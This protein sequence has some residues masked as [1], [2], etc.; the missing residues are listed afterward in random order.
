MY[1]SLLLKRGKT[2]LHPHAF[3]HVGVLAC[4]EFNHVLR[5]DSGYDTQTD[6]WKLLSFLTFWIL[7]FGL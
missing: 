7:E 6:V 3:A 5:F 2:L 4:L 1:V